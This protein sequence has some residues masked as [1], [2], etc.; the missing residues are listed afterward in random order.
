MSKERL[1]KFI[2]DVIFFLESELGQT[3]PDS[4]EWKIRKLTGKPFRKV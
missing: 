3:V 1:L 2:N 4:E